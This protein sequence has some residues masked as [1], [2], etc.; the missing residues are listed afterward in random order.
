MSPNRMIVE[1]AVVG[2]LAAAMMSGASAQERDNIGGHVTARADGNHM[3]AT[4]QL[5]GAPRQ[6]GSHYTTVGGMG[7]ASVRENRGFTA[8]RV[9]EG[10]RRFARVGSETRYGLRSDRREFGRTAVENG[11]SWRGDRL[12]YSD[13]GIGM[14]VVAEDYR[15]DPMPHYAYYPRPVYAYAPGYD[16]G[17]SVDPYYEYAPRYNVPYYEEGPEIGVDIGP[18]GIGIGPDWGRW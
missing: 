15:Y 9:V 2:C 13:R 3:R 12:A 16:A 1:V 14:G 11:S 8:G 17:Y 18:V 10:E 7:E 5:N 4:S 6:G